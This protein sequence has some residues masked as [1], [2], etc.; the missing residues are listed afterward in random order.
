M[1]RKFYYLALVALV[2]IAFSSCSFFGGGGN[3]PEYR[4]SDLQ[5]L[6]KNNS[7]N[8]YVRFT[9]EE[10]EEAGYLLGL[11]WNLDEDKTEQDRLDAR[12]ELG[13]P[14]NGW[15]KYKFEATGDLHELHLMDNEGA[16]EPKE[17]IVTKLTDTDLVYY[18]KDYN[19]RTT[20]F[21]KVVEPK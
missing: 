3:N 14:G 9:T 6:W 8:E 20:S 5:G 17:Y 4:L 2:S 10:S 15:F 7:K 21:S 1:G 18:E 16:E 19:S 11:E 13:H 12:E